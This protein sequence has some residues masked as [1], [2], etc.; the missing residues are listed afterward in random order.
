MSAVASPAQPHTSG[1][2]TPGWRR[3]SARW[4]DGPGTDRRSGAELAQRGEQRVPGGL[5]TSRAEAVREFLRDLG[6][7]LPR[8]LHGLAPALGERQEPGPLV[9]RGGPPFDVAAADQL[10]GRLRHG[11]LGDREPPRQL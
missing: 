7:G 6:A 5:Y 4:A 8:G 10:R 2:A 1:H 9:V 3:G 11:L